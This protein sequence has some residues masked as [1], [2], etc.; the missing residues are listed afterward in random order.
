MEI[1]HRDY[2]V[3]IGFTEVYVRAGVSFFA[4]NPSPREQAGPS[5]HNHC[6]SPIR[7]VTKNE[8]KVSLVSDQTV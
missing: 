1:L 4:R 3:I 8:I 6:C 5:L 7:C 2:L